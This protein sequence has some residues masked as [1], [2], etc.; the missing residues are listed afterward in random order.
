[1]GNQ[2]LMRRR[3]AAVLVGTSPLHLPYISPTS[4]LHLPYISPTS[5]LHLAYISLTSPLHL[6]YISTVF[7]PQHWWVYS[8]P[9][10]NTLALALALALPLARW[11]DIARPLRWHKGSP[12]PDPTL[13]T[14]AVNLT[15]TL[16]LTLTRALP[17]YPYPYPYRY[18]SPGNWPTELCRCMHCGALLFLTLYNT[19]TTPV[20]PL[21]SV[22]STAP[23]LPLSVL[24]AW[25]APAPSPH[26]LPTISP[27]S[28]HHLP[29][30]SHHLPTY[31]P[32]TPHHLARGAL[33]WS[34]RH[35]V[36][37]ARRRRSRGQAGEWL[38][39]LGASGSG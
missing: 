9:N 37:P 31:S 6:P 21:Y 22:L 18:P 3:A 10:P 7:P 15:L 4:P 34:Q 36:P 2:L 11:V 5:P 16:T 28:P 20:L 1:M 39:G 35:L 38:G 12:G 32:P 30:I 23:L 13:M 29:A 24:L 26:H 17:P 27:P 14:L 33:P 25:S 19:C 8:A